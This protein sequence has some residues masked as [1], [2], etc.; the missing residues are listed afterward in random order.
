VLTFVFLACASVLGLF[1]PGDSLLIGAGVLLA[2]EGDEP[3]A[4][5]LG[6]VATAVAVGGNQVGTTARVCSTRCRG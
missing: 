3:G 5:V 6:G 4:L 2:G 1:L